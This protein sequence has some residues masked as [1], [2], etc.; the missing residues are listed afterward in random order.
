LISTVSYYC[1][2][3]PAMNVARRYGKRWH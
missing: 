2:E 3:Q 1:V